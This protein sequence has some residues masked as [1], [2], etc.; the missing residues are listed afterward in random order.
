MN[1]G[2][3]VQVRMKTPPAPAEWKQGGWRG[4]EKWTINLFHRDLDVQ[5]VW[6]HVSLART[7][8]IYYNYVPLNCTSG[9]QL[10]LSSGTENTWSEG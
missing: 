3:V 2:G 6:E 8:L 4:E 1:S 7:H 10:T 9:N 5:Y